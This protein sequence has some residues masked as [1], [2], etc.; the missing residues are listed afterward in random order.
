[1]GKKYKL[2]AVAP[3]LPPQR[4]A[5]VENRTALAAAEAAHAAAVAHRDELDLMINGPQLTEQQIREQVLA[6]KDALQE[7]VRSGAIKAGRKP[8]ISFAKRIGLE[9]TLEGQ[10]HA[11][12]L[13][14]AATSDADA[15]VERT[16]STVAELRAKIADIE[17]G[18]V[19]EVADE[20]GRHYLGLIDKAVTAL[21]VLK[22]LDLYLGRTSLTAGIN[23]LRT[24]ISY[25]LASLPCMPRHAKATRR[26]E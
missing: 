18:V 8:E 25:P 17:R 5:L 16:G 23:L 12:E 22:S 21:T 24:D 7:W 14:A 26:N 19:M 1:M 20:I 4:A 10:R 2:A 6:D 11:A 13:A 3:S 15:D 9:E